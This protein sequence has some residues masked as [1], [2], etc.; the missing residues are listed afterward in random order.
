MNIT[1]EVPDYQVIKSDGTGMLDVVSI[2]IKQITDLSYV[3]DLYDADGNCIAQDRRFF[4]DKVICTAL[5]I[6]EEGLING[7]VPSVEWT[8]EEIKMYLTIN[9]IEYTD[10]MT[11]PD[12]LSLVDLD[13]GEVI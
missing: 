13:I 9:G 5:T 6:G 7:T 8:I 3:G 1:K 10:D 4:K 12:L 11:E 2:T